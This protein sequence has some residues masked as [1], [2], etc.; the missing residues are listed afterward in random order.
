[1]TQFIIGLYVCLFF[2]I[3]VSLHSIIEL[4][5][6]RRK[7]AS[8]LAFASALRSRILF[9]AFLAV[10]CLSRFLIISQQ[11]YLYHQVEEVEPQ[12][13]EYRWIHLLPILFFLSAFS[14]I[15]VFFSRLYH[16]TQ[17]QQTD[18]MSTF[19]F[20][21]N[22]IVYVAFILISVFTF[23]NQPD[24]I[25]MNLF[26]RLS[27][28]CFAISFFVSAASL[29]FYGRRISLSLS[30][31]V[32]FRGGLDP[33]TF[34]KRRCLALMIVIGTVFF[35]RGIYFTIEST[36]QSEIRPSFIPDLIWETIYFMIFECIPSVIC[37]HLLNAKPKTQNKDALLTVV[38]E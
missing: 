34:L 32:F 27:F 16:A 3:G 18:L 28:I 33:K 25:K 17:S 10:A 37:C 19:Y 2:Y 24:S 7:L 22:S 26:K 30:N 35:G 6:S 5:V 14:V 31:A 8:Q 9:Y 1:M 15:V 13:W 12:S 4:I 38:N 11:V 21:L 29:L 23:S 20:Y 36:L